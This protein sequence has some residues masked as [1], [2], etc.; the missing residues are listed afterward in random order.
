MVSSASEG[1]LC[2]IKLCLKITPTVTERVNSAKKE[3][4]KKRIKTEH[5]NQKIANMSISGITVSVTEVK[6]H[7]SYTVMCHW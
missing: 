1:Y 4:R 7:Q 5:F 6:T 3:K 2:V